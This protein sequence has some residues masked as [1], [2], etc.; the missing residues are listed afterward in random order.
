MENKL[1]KEL[2]DCA[3]SVIDNYDRKFPHLANIL[4]DDL[5]QSID[6]LRQIINLSNN[7]VCQRC[8]GKG[9]IQHDPGD[10]APWVWTCNICGGKGCE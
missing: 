9:K 4:A 3:Q 2:V 8:G 7:S 1:F 6:R 5:T 10:E